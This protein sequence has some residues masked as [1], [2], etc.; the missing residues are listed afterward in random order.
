M[1]ASSEPSRAA[2]KLSSSLISLLSALCDVGM[3]LLTCCRYERM[4][5]SGRVEWY[6]AWCSGCNFC[7]CGYTN[8]LLVPLISVLILVLSDMIPS[9]IKFMLLLWCRLLL[10]YC[11]S[12]T[13][14]TVWCH[15]WELTYLLYGGWWWRVIFISRRMVMYFI[16]FRSC[17]MNL[18]SSAA[19]P[20]MDGRMSLVV[21]L[22]VEL[23]A[24]SKS[25][26][27]VL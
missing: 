18:C 5:P 12:S 13:C 19:L 25:A 17:L 24:V 11:C 22:A 2:R 8:R 20:V 15:C 4:V 21:G 9:L 16:S 1:L 27:L 14:T 7:F 23:G 10:H 26:W 6:S 3:E